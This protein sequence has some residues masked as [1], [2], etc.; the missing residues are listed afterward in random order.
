MNPLRL[1]RDRR[2]AMMALGATLFAA[3]AVSGALL[4]DL[5]RAHLVRLRLQ[6]AVDAAAL[7][8][9]RELASGT[10]PAAA[11]AERVFDANAH[12][13]LWDAAPEPLSVA[14]PGGGAGV[15]VAAEARLPLALGR[16]SEAVAP[17]RARLRA[18]ATAELATPPT[19]LAL[20]LDASSSMHGSKM[21]ALQAAATSLLQGLYGGETSIPGFAAAITP[22][23]STVNIGQGRTR[24]VVGAP[25][26]WS[27]CVLPRDGALA[28]TDESPARGLFP[29]F[30]S[31]SGEVSG[32]KAGKFCP[33]PILPLTASRAALQA[34]V[35][36]LGHHAAARRRRRNRRRRGHVHGHDPRRVRR[37]RRA[38]R[39]D[40][41]RD[42]DPQ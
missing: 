27:G 41:L 36:A 5:S 18:A 42:G 32:K 40:A 30:L 11:M 39:G 16:L 28:E 10:T 25:A 6:A 12:A 3:L 7:A 37:R 4:A 8:A 15:E 26:E 35:D 9:A 29:P 34:A 33:D 24:W 13:S 22:F 17:D 2:G 38:T 31:P 21:R 14:F 1:L 20:V 19:E 23:A